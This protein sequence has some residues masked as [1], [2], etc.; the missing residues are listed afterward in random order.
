MSFVYRTGQRFGISYLVDVLLGKA[1]DR[2]KKYG[3]DKVSTFGIGLEYD[4]SQWQDLYRQL[5]TQSYLMVDIN[6][7]GGLKL[8]LKG[9]DA[10]RGREIIKLRKQMKPL[11]STAKKKTEKMELTNPED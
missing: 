8:T 4:K 2:M 7:H 11:K 5:V 3:H 9:M 1:D 10:I 6:A